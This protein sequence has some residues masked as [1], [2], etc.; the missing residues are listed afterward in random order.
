MRRVNPHLRR[1][2]PAAL[3]LALIVGAVSFATRPKP[4]AVALGTLGKGPVEATLAN[5]RAGSIEACQR[6]R[7]STILGGR[8]ETLSVK[9]GD[10]VRK[11]DVLLRLWNEDQRAQTALAEA[12]L[13]TARQ[14]IIEACALAASA[15][16]EADRQRDLAARGFVS[17]SRA[18]TAAAEADLRAAACA[19]ART[20]VAQAEARV[21]VTRVEQGRTTL[22]APFSGIVAKIVGER[23]EYTTPSP[24][25]VATPP[26]IDLIDD[27]CLFVEAPMD[28][29][30]APRIRPGQPARVR[31]DSLPE[32]VFAARVRRI[33]PVVSAVEKQ[34]RT[35]DIELD[36]VDSAEAAGLLVGYS[37][38][39]EIILAQREHT[40]RVPTS[41]LL[42]GNR[43]LVLGDDGMLASRELQVGL[44][45]W[46]FT[47]VLAGATEGERIVVSLEREGVRAGAR[48]VADGER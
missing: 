41:A 32:K 43:V 46:E 37:A 24:P 40:L 14:R 45:N 6:T 12:Q 34:A 31:L 4:V 3:V 11:G 2:L 44:S 26:A 5:T 15:R 17:M 16:H 47:E 29:V 35:V 33:A 27:S 8:I 1:L 13:A 38:D 20:D 28:E 9:E 19:S 23:G 36:F 10:H 7:L 39:V 21:R 22:V 30:D 48:A 42:P 18:E 25:G